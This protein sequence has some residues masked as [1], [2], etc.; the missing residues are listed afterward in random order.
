MDSLQ[1][2]RFALGVF[3]IPVSSASLPVL[4]SPVGVLGVSRSYT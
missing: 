2:V 1:V 3:D 4:F